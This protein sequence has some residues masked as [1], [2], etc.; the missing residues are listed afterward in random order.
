MSDQEEW[1]PVVGWEGL[2]EVSSWGN[3]NTVEHRAPSRGGVGFKTVPGMRR[4]TQLNAHGYPVVCLR[5][6]KLVKLRVVH[7]MVVEAFIGPIPDGMNTNHLDGVRSNNRLQNLEICTASE[8]H[9]HRCRVM[10]RGRGE[11]HNLALLDN[12]KAI[13][14]RA[15]YALRD[16]NYGACAKLARKYGVSA[17]VIQ[18]V[19]KWK[20]WKHVSSEAQA[21]P[22]SP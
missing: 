6:G 13:A 18:S 5:R 4:K 7:R 3:V 17:G 11:T 14:I 22:A 21:Q 9:L 15:E 19:V 16:R 1:R 8:N 20:N 12:A 10:G 2:Y